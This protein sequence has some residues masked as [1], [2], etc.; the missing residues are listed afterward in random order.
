MVGTGIGIGKGR[1]R[2]AGTGTG[3]GI[4]KGAGTREEIEIGIGIGIVIGNETVTGRGNGLIEQIGEEVGATRMAPETRV[5]TGSV[6]PRLFWLSVSH[7][8]L[9][10]VLRFGF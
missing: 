8:S 5:M 3:I 4:G 7:F 1:R 10:F 9:L 2:A 6:M